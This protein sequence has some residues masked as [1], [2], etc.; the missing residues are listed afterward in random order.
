MT[1]I[2]FVLRDLFRNPRRTLTSLVGVIVGVGLF[3]AV[4]FFIDGSGASLTRRAL[5]PLT[6]DSQLVL[7]APLGGGLRFEQALAADALTAGATT[8]VTLT[9]TNDGLASAH[10]VVIRDYPGDPLSYVPGSTTLDGV[11]VQDVN[12]GLPLYQGNAGIGL[13]IGTVEPGAS[14]QVNYLLKATSQVPSTAD[15]PVNA[16]ISAREARTPAPANAP[17]AKSLSSLAERVVGIPG[18]QA[19]AARSWCARS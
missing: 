8:L 9:V 1:L 4:L 10:E 11:E 16:T 5:A 6:L 12:G 3:S 7:T 14:R 2:G 15:L 18:V 19:K 13:N 17:P